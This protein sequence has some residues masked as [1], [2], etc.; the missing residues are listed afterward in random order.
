M[1]SSGMADFSEVTSGEVDGLTR[2]ALVFEAKIRPSPVALGLDV[3]HDR[4]S[5][6][7]VVG[8]VVMVV[9]LGLQ[10]REERFGDRVDVPMVSTC[11]VS[12]GSGRPNWTFTLAG[13]GWA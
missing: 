8:E 13:S 2:S 4:G 11:S 10:V 7:Q 9:H 3:L 12:Q 6:G 1:S 5:S